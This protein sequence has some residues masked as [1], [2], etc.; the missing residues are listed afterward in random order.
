LRGEALGEETLRVVMDLLDDAVLVVQ[1]DEIV[2]CNRAA[3]DICGDRLVGRP[4]QEVFDAGSLVV[5]EEHMRDVS[6][7]GAFTHVYGQRLRA[8]S[9][10]PRDVQIALTGCGWKE[11][12]ATLLVCKDT[13]ATERARARL[14]ESEGRVQV[15]EAMASGA[16]LSTILAALVEMA[17]RNRPGL[18]GA[19]F[20]VDVDSGELTL[21]AAPSV[22]A[23]LRDGARASLERGCHRMLGITSRLIIE[24]LGQAVADADFRA[25][26]QALDIEGFWV[27]PVFSATRELLGVLVLCYRAPRRPEPWDVEFVQSVAHLAG[28]AI[29]RTRTE[30]ALR[31]S[32]ER[33]RTLLEHAPEAV[34]VLDVGTGRLIEA[35]RQA[36]RLLGWSRDALSQMHPTDFSPELQPDGQR[37]EEASVALLTAA[38]QGEV[39]EQ[40]WTHL[41]RDG[42]VVPVALTLVALP[43]SG[44][45]LIR[46]SLVDLRERRRH[47]QERAALEGEVRHKQKLSAIG[48]LASGVAHEINN[49]IQGIMG[50]AE[51]IGHHTSTDTVSRRYADEIIGEA[52]RVAT[53]VRSL[54]TFARQEA[55]PGLQL[56]SI[57][58]IVA[59]TLSLVQTLLRKDAIELEVELAEGMAPVRCRGQQLRQVLMNLL[60]NARDAVNARPRAAGERKRIAL[61]SG[62]VEEEGQ[63][64]VRVTVEDNGVGI[65]V[66]L[67]ERIFEPFFTTKVHSQ[68]TGM[69]LSISHGI[70]AEHQGRLSV[71]SRPG[72]TCF[73][74][75]LPVV[76][77]ASS[78]HVQ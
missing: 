52:E 35:N 57:G 43:S 67:Q 30:E 40:E 18:F 71:E 69:G 17:E 16:D 19:V 23:S 14:R 8:S 64:W 72:R 73:Q 62:L 63:R 46:G 33:Y 56:T 65:P 3:V 75:E 13:A 27:E 34:M 54:L 1:Q 37:S 32:E 10:L 38:L 74:L 15:L 53:I 59:S 5:L 61:R 9:G 22:P 60:T 55:E 39:V 47:A 26:A 66:E 21:A 25:L 48:T 50:Y 4:L 12:A 77:G 41:H 58:E 42:T 51:L 44:S 28:I 7:S 31:L 49:P 11:G 20:V 36:E 45:P 29:A 68:G 70:V 78:D 6:V 24:D 76:D 2:A